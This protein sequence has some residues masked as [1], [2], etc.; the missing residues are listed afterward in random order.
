MA[1]FNND[2]NNNFGSNFNNASFYPT[3]STSAFE[4]FD[5]YPLD[6]H[7]FL[8]H[9][10]ATEEV[11]L[12]DYRTFDNRWG[13]VARPGPMVGSPTNPQAMI[14]YGNRHYSLSVD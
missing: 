12:P 11:D 5:A 7:P 4:E 9:T 14:G 13:M 8:N 1:Y 2:V 10:S 6:A 3:P